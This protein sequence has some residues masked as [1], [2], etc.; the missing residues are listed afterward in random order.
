MLW[1]TGN[2]PP[3][4]DVAAAPLDV[5]VGAE[6][7]AVKDVAPGFAFMVVAAPLIVVTAGV[8]VATGLPLA[9]TEIQASRGDSVTRETL[10]IAFG[11]RLQRDLPD[12]SAT[13]FAD[14]MLLNRVARAMK[15]FIL[16][17]YIA[18]PLYRPITWRILG[19]CMS[20]NELLSQLR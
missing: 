15:L 11:E 6:S 12:L 16:N 18:C 3:P 13:G 20:A 8:I 2:D 7:P 1:Q 19:N 14:M 4:V 10:A 9:S 5:A 17:A